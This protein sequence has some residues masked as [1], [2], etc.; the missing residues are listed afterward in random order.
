[1]KIGAWKK[2]LVLKVGKP[3]QADGCAN[4]SFKGYRGMKHEAFY[5]TLADLP[6]MN[7]YD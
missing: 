4:V 7:P 6:M 2:L 3:F 1:M 5:F